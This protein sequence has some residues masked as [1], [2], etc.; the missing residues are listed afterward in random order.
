MLV[1]ASFAIHH[2]GRNRPGTACKAQQRGLRPQS[3]LHCRHRIIN[4]RETLRHRLKALQR[5]IDQLGR[6]P[7]PL[8]LQE[9]QILPHRIGDD[10]D[11]GKQDCPVKTEPPDRLQRDFRRSLRIVNQLEK[12][13][14]FGPQFAI[15]GQIPSGLAHEPHGHLVSAFAA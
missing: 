1:A 14:F 15:F 5:M 12:P 7:W 11:V 6:Q 10:Q 9:L 3:T 4:R 8:A 2:V 13:A